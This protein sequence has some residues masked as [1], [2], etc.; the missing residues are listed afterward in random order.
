MKDYQMCIDRWQFIKFGALS[1]VMLT[2][3]SLDLAASARSAE[4][5]G[6][7]A[8]TDEPAASQATPITHV[9]YLARQDQARRYM[10]DEGIDGILLTGGSSLHYFTGIDWGLSERLFAMVFP[11]DGRP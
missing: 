10:R 6:A 5:A 1:T 9:E 8:I 7:A 3:G 11:A 2:G 4:E